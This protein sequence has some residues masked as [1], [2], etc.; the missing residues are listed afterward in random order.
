MNFLC[1]SNHNND[2]SWIKDY[3]NPYVIYDRSDNDLDLKD[4]N[5]IKSPNLGY[6]IYDICTFIIDNYENLPDYT[7]F[8]KGNIFPRHISREKFEKLM[9]NK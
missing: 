8:C 9:N 1:I 3:K 2:L 7:T 5:V 4:L 6:N